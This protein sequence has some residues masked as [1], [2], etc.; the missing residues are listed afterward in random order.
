M[1]IR[2]L[3]EEL[4]VNEDGNLFIE[5]L[6]MNVPNSKTYISSGSQTIIFDKDLSCVASVVAI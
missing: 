3:R 4:T 5:F 2:S 1:N 6:N